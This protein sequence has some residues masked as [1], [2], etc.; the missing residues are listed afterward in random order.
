[1]GPVNGSRRSRIRRRLSFGAPRDAACTARPSILLAVGLLAAGLAACGGGST[2]PTAPTGPEPGYHGPSGLVAY[3]AN[4][5]DQT[6]GFVQAVCLSDGSLGRRI[7]VGGQPFQIAIAPGGEW[8]YVANSGWDGPRAQRTVTPINLK[9]QRAGPPIEAGL[10]PMGIAI[11]PDGST[12]YVADMG[13]FLNGQT[14]TM[15]DADTVTPIDLADRRPMPAIPVGP[16]VGAVSI[17]PDGK[18]ALVAVDGTDSHPLSYIE[19]LDLA[20]GRL[21]APIYV[22]AA[23][24]SIAITPDGSKALVTDTGFRPIGHTVTPIDLATGAVGKDIPVGNAPIDIVTTPD[25]RTAYVADT[26]TAQATSFASTGVV[27]TIDVAT[28]TA[29][30]AISVPGVPQALAMTPDGTTVYEVGLEGGNRSA[31]APIDV[32]TGKVGPAIRFHAN[33]GAVTIAPAPAGQCR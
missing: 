33:L 12:A 20:T 26:S 19:T 18:E 2:A 22:G 17:T 25:G 23:P 27:S 1:M 29:G 14:S 13:S 16:G 5:Y 10:G 11:T 15:V 32:A 6:S 8:A 4:T 30:R 24:M 7:P 31:L 3:V 9:T 28:D 21:S